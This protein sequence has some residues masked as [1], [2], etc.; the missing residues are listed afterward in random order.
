[1]A[2]K[3]VDEIAEAVS[4]EEVVNT[5]EVVEPVEHIEE[6]DNSEVSSD[7]FN[8]ED[9]K[10]EIEVK[11]V[12]HVDSEKIKSEPIQLERPRKVYARPNTRSNSVLT[13]GP[14]TITGD[15]MGD[16]I[17]VEGKFRQIGQSYGWICRTEAR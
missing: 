2:K 7:S 17:K 13:S 12:E 3:K 16:F 15:R 5:V 4:S 9:A 10:T 14:M 6:I 8:K 11:E 1:M